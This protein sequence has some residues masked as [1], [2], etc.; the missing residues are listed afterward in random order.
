MAEGFLEVYLIMVAA[1]TL[2][3]LIIGFVFAKKHRKKGAI[4]GTI[5]GIIL[6]SVFASIAAFDA[7]PTEEVP[8]VVAE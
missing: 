3:G 2:L 7:S 4:V 5:A 6:G 8:T 1:W